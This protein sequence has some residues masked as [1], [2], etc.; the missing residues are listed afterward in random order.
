MQMAPSQTNVT[1]RAGGGASI[2]SDGPVAPRPRRHEMELRIYQHSNLFYWW[3][4]WAYGYVCAAFTYFQGAQ[5]H[6]SDTRK[7]LLF[8]PSPW[9]GISFMG[10]VLFVAVFTNVRARGIYSFMLIVSAMML[11]LALSHIPGVSRALD[12]VQLLRV[13][14]NLAFYLIFSILLMFIWLLVIIFVDRF[15]WWRFSP[16]QV[17]EEHKV[18][19]ATGQTYNTEGMVIGRLPDEFFRHRVLGLG[20]LGYGT[21]D[22]IVKPNNQQAF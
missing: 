10:L 5:I 13:H 14:L 21:G 18:G 20:V 15:V 12:L 3:I 17:V 4:L 6:L 9:L 7:T 19:H 8:H 2:P 1:E 11:L 22:F 16:G